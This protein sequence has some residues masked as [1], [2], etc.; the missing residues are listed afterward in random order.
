MSV[1]HHKYMAEK[2]VFFSLLYKA[3]NDVFNEK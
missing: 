1:M 2:E 3:Y